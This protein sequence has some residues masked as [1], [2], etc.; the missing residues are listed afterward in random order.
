MA[1]DAVTLIKD[2]HRLLEDL[3]AHLQA[4]KGDRQQLVEEITVR[5]TA[6]AEA[7]EQQVYPAVKKADPGQTDEVDH[8]YTEHA[9]A[10]HLLQKVRNLTGSPHFYEAVNAFV[11]AV[12]HHVDEEESDVLPALQQAVDAATLK[13]L[14]AAFAQDRATILRRAGFDPGDDLGAASGDDAAELTEATRDELYEMAKLAHIPGR[15]SMNKDDLVRALR[16]NG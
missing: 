1:S 6:H 11:D 7:E 5:L 13:R 14:G 10:M 12:R 2:D 9:E 4:D 16:E 8:A 15:S 3:F